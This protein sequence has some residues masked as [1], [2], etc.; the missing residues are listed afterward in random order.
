MG[1]IRFSNQLLSTSQPASVQ[2]IISNLVL[3]IAILRPLDIFTLSII[4]FI[5]WPS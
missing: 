3:E 1:L 4:S 2:A 5:G